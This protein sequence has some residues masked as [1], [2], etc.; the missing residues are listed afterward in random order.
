MF[1]PKSRKIFK[2]SDGAKIIGIDP[3][4]AQVALESVDLDWEAE[5]LKIRQLK[6][7]N[8]PKEI[9]KEANKA[10]MVVADAARKAFKL[11]EFSIDQETG[12]E[13]GLTSVDVLDL[14]GDFVQWRAELQSFFEQ[15]LTSPPSTDGTAAVT[16]NGTDS[17]STSDGRSP[18]TASV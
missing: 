7:D 6:M 16:A 10:A 14:L 18:A 12:A 5:F 9:A 13:S 4:E 17:T 15:A 2:Y 3:L 11:P 8:P 1:S